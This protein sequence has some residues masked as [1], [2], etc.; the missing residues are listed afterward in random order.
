MTDNASPA[1]RLKEARIGA[2]FKSAAQAARLNGWSEVTYRHHENGTRNIPAGM[3]RI[4]ASAFRVSP[5]W[6]LGLLEEDPRSYS[7]ELQGGLYTD[8]EV[9][10]YGE[11][12]R[13]AQEHFGAAMLQMINLS[14]LDG[15]EPHLNASG[16]HF[17]VDANLLDFAGKDRSETP[18]TFHAIRVDTGSTPGY[19]PD[20]V[21]IVDV[22]S[23]QIKRQGS[24]MVYSYAGFAGIATVF[25]HPDNSLELIGVRQS[26]DAWRIPVDQVQLW[27]TVVLSIRREF[28]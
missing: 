21:V 25:R 23:S 1:E 4:Y 5:G 11:Y 8:D 15:P 26:D 10:K 7:A 20:D 12:S 3:A 17:A 24:V 28:W 18:L 14:Q 6:L 22:A 19:S 9:K 13:L 16:R 2:G 27:G